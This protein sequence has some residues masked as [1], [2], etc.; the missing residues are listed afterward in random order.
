MNSDHS[1]LPVNRTW[2]LKVVFQQ[3]VLL[4]GFSSVSVA[5]LDILAIIHLHEH[6]L[7][8]LQEQG[9]ES[10]LLHQ[11]C[12]SVDQGIWSSGCCTGKCRHSPLS[13]VGSVLGIPAGYGICVPGCRRHSPQL[14]VH[15]RDDS[16]ISSHHGQVL[17]WR[18]ASSARSSAQTH[19]QLP[20]RMVWVGCRQV[21]E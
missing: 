19:H 7:S 3:V 16:W 5:S 9:C 18:M 2:T 21:E 13:L 8:K 15:G 6:H 17:S 4:L 1:L 12:G 20:R 14:G 10:D 11:G